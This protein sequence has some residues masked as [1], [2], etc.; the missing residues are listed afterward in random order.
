MS[1]DDAAARPSNWFVYVVRCSDGSLYTGVSTDVPARIAVHNAGRGAK[2][3]RS[4]LPVELVYQEPVPDRGAALR[5]EYRIRRLP[6][7]AKRALVAGLD[8]PGG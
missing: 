2:Y 6:G 5:R 3:T 8:T 4:R 1:T 7:S